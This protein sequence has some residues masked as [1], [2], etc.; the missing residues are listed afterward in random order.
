MIRPRIPGHPVTPDPGFCACDF[1]YDCDPD[2][3]NG[4]DCQCDVECICAC[5]QTFACDPNCGNCDPE[6][7]GGLDCACTSVQTGG[8]A[9]GSLA[10][11]GLLAGLVALRRR[12]T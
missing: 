1:T 9:G 10:L 8:A 11:I 3:I 7:D 12:R 5:D 4:G 6:C 2:Q